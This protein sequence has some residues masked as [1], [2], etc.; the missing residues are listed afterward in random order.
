MR[1][2]GRLASGAA[3]LVAA[4]TG[5]SS[6]Q[7]ASAPNSEVSSNISSNVP[8]RTFVVDAVSI[9]E[10]WWNWQGAFAE[11]LNPVTDTSGDDCERGQPSDG[12]WFVAG[13]FGNDAGDTTRRTCNIPATQVLERACSAHFELPG[14][15]PALPNARTFILFGIRTQH[16]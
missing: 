12:W 8:S 15:K 1:S 13:T 5:C 6:S 3:V 4:L 7:T 14:R 9:T 2:L 16:T 11:D 10:R